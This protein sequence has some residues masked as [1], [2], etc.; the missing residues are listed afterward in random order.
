MAKLLL[1]LA[2]AA[3]VPVV[4]WYVYML[5]FP[6]YYMDDEYPYWKQQ[7]DYVNN[8]GE[9]NDIII[10]GDST[11]KAA[12]CTDCDDN[13]SIYNLAL[14]GATSAEM[15]V[16]L[17]NYLKA[18]DKPKTVV[19]M[20][21]AKNLV[22]HPKFWDRTIYF[23]FYSWSELEELYKK[24]QELNDPFW[25]E[26]GVELKLLKYYFKDP[27]RYLAAVNNS[28]FFGRY[29][30]N[31]NLY[32]QLER[33]KG[34]MSFGTSDGAYGENFISTLE[35]FETGSMEDNYIRR[36]IELCGENDI[37]VIVE[38]PPVK[39]SAIGEIRENVLSEYEG[40]FLQLQQD[41]PYARVNT[42]LA[43]YDNVY[44]GDEDHLNR[45]GAEMYTAEII[46]KYFKK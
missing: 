18:H 44:F 27:N 16:T 1:K 4:L 29:S 17:R 13:L 34:W 42:S 10:L 37:E 6:M 7:K 26:D 21:A 30:E 39:A 5:V 24:G 41:Y 28:S 8:N 14:G 33:D 31:V 32:E 46:D 22:S 45:K 19:M 23:N 2:S 25:T 11:T 12:F 43:Y 40:Y 35:S 9:C 38:Q 15:Y 3:M 20:F 36:I